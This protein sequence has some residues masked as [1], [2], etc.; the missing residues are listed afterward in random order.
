MPGLYGI[1]IDSSDMVYLSILAS[2]DEVVDRIYLFTSEGQF[3]TSFGSGLKN[4][5]GLAVDNSGVLYVCD[6]NCVQLF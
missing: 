3:V 5:R 1:A 6:S 4:P 2:Y